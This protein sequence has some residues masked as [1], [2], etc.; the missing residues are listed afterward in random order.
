MSPEFSLLVRI[1]VGL[2]LLVWWVGLY[3]HIWGKKH[4]PGFF[5][6]AGILLLPLFVSLGWALVSATILFALTAVILRQ[7]GKN[8]KRY[9]QAEARF[10]GG[11]I[12]RGLTTP[13]AAAV[14]GRP[15]EVILAV[16]LVDMLQKGFLELNGPDTVRLN[17]VMQTRNRSL[18]PE[19]RAV[20]RRAG[21][22]SIMATLHPF[23][24]PILELIEQ[25]AGKP[26]S[27]L[28]WG[29]V[30]RPFMRHVAQ[31]IAGYDMEASR[32]Y[33]RLLIRRAP[34]EA[35]TEGNLTKEREKVYGRNLGWLLLNPD[36]LT[37]LGS[38]VDGY[39][40]AWFNIGKL[41][42]SF[43]EWFGQAASIVGQKLTEQDLELRLGDEID[44]VS[45][46]L[47]SEIARAT[48]NG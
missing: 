31:R 32:E 26:L 29:L 14:L 27:Q 30:I 40:P 15:M 39:R 1:A 20:F 19:D 8:R 44:E 17:E 22:Q 2:T 18:N 13:E 45:A 12:K 28:G 7:R 43:G 38:G 37:F 25:D 16:A 3:R 9:V 47:M 24:E 41:Q 23:E 21:A 34:I 33:Y 48:Y 35:R 42:G 6:V 10:E 5:A 11:G 4:R 36:L 46:N